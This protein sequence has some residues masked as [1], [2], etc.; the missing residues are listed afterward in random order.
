MALRDGLAAEYCFAGDAQDTSGCR[1]H[2]IVHGA[3]LTADRFGRAA[4]AYQFDGVDDFI[5]ILEPPA[6]SSDAMSVS[7]WARYDPRD[8]SGYTN[9]IVA[10]DDGNDEDQ[11]RRVFQI[12]TLGG[13]I[14]WHRMEHVRDPMCRRR[15]RPGVWTHIVAVHDHGANRLFVDGILHDATEHRLWTHASQPMHI[16]RKGTPEPYFFFR[17]AIDD[18]RVYDRA[19][20]G[21][22]VGEL[23]REGGWTAPAPP[24]IEGDPLSGRWGRDGVVVLDL[25][26]DGRGR[27]T[28]QIMGGRPSNMAPIANGTFDRATSRLR[29]EGQARH[30]N[31]G[32][33]LP[34]SID[35]MLDQGE[36]TVTARYDDFAGNVVLTRRGARMRWTKRSVRSQIGAVA[37][38][39]RELAGR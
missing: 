9:C 14:V 10:Q 17:G 13:H 18:V 36:I 19:L 15:V 28:G 3:T 2:G 22:E 35:G 27:V 1:R 25:R 34:Y 33:V 11:A 4:H 31:R 6:F 24:P 20:G 7:A 29:L 38:W 21:V 37:F 8:F 23:L 39:L 5:E 26:Y 32:V 12:S 16:G 30:P